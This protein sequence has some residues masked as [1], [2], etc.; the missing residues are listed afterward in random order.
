ME[1]RMSR[2]RTIARIK[3]GPRGLSVA[4]TSGVRAQL[5]RTER[6]LRRL[7]G[8]CSPESQQR[9]AGVE[10][11]ALLRRVVYLSLTGESGVSGE[12]LAADR[13]LPA[14]DR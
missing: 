12:T 8:L 13:A 10:A 5:L 9:K 11:A 1:G 6:L 4:F 3:E 2:Q 7:N 14:G